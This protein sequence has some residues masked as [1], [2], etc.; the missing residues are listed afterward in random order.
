MKE[1]CV[2]ILLA[3]YNGEL[4]IEQ[5]IQSILSQTYKN[6]HL[7]ISDDSSCDNTAAIIKKYAAMDTR[8][9]VL[10]SA[11]KHRSAKMNFFYLIECSESSYIAFCDQDDYWKPNK[12]QIS[13]ET[14][15]EIER[16]HGSNIPVLVHTDLS[17]TDERLDIVRQSMV[18]N[19]NIDPINHSY[20]SIFVTGFVTGCT[21]VVNR[22]CVKLAMTAADRKNIIMHDWW[23]CLIAETFGKRRFIPERTVL[24]RQHSK[25]SI[26][27]ST[28]SL[29]C[30]I[31]KWLAVVC[32][33]GFL[34]SMRIARK[35][36]QMRF[37]QAKLFLETYENI[38][39]PS[40]RLAIE[41]L[42]SIE[43]TSVFKRL[44]LMSEC[45]LWR[46]G[47]G[48]RFKQAILIITL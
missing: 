6:W 14:L 48:Y 45:K 42:L 13:M 33:L 31:K 43:N 41:R 21:V 18:K 10:T 35:N 32:K 1:P 39:Q 4:Y 9:H 37:K 2:D 15:R 46:K 7:L 34:H 3:T 27:A 11:A 24:Y 5:Q 25:N 26:G 23:L 22:S 16:N 29:H 44:H 28:R 47:L 40:N 8:I 38:I 17:I 20:E 12:I 36:E 19:L 30:L